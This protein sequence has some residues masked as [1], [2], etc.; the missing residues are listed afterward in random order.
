MWKV[1][2]QQNQDIAAYI[3]VKDLSDNKIIKFLFLM[4]GLFLL[5]QP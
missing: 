5:A 3:Q 2:S 4:D 1:E